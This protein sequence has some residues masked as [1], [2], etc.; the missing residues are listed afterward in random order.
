MALLN[1]PDDGAVD[2]APVPE[3]VVLLPVGVGWPPVV[4]L[5]QISM[6]I[7]SN[8]ICKTYWLPGEV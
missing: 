3:G 8:E 1:A 6:P 7:Q 2:G 4:V 5:S